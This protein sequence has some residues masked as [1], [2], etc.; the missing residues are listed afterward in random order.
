MDILELNKKAWENIGSRATPQRLEENKYKKM[1]ELFCTKLPKNARVLDL[2]CGPGR[3]AKE[4][5]CWGFEVIGIDLAGKMIKLAKKKAPKAKYL[6]M[7]MTEI[8][9]HDEFD[10]VVS[11]FSMLCLDP[12]N[13]RKTAQKISRA[14]KK[15]GLFLLSL[16]EP[17]PEK[18]HN[19]E[20]N[21]TEIMGQKI[22]SRPYTEEEIKDIFSEYD[23]EIKCVKREIL[24]SKEY[25]EEYTLIILMQKT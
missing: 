15:N 5:T 7:S 21:Y 17:H 3:I 19:E 2:G 22:Y 8:K 20:D 6:Q 12:E 4:L 9:F 1:F 11:S 24:T 13:F 23:V 10:G 18:S 16:N 14:L 25:G